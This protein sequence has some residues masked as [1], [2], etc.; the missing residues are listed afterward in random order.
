MA[1]QERTNRPQGTPR[2]NPGSGGEKP[3]G[4]VPT[5]RNPPPPPPKKKD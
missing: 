4:Q 1:K 5:M 3:K 2:N